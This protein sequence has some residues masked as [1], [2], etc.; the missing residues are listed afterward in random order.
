MANLLMTPPCSN[1]TVPNP[2]KETPKYSLQE[3]MDAIDAEHI[4]R[5]EMNHIVLDYL[6]SGKPST[7][8]C[9]E[10]VSAVMHRL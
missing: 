3:W 4:P 10:M 2:L 7:E 9:P 1:A 5:T 6:I 8:F